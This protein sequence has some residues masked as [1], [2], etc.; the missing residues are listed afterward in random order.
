MLKSALSQK[1]D[2]EYKYWNKGKTLCGVDE[3]GR[4][5]V[6]GSVFA[7]VVSISPSSLEK[8]NKKEQAFIRDSK[9][10]SKTQRLT[11][12]VIVKKVASFFAI[13]QANVSEIENKGILSATF[14]AMRRALLLCPSYDLLLVDGKQK[15]PDL[16]VLQVTVIG[17]DK[18]CFTI[19]AASI[20]AKVAR[21]AYMTKM[22]AYYP[23]YAFAQHV[24]YYTRQHRERLEKFGS[25]AL[26]RRNFAPIKWN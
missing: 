18:F 9:T 4:G 1:G 5:C 10:L 7:A 3:V 11:A 15:I 14:L 6:A 8:V 25:C 16:E 24:G 21:D 2:I 13:A 20:L 17:G 19:A 12:Q 26:H 22:D 23:D